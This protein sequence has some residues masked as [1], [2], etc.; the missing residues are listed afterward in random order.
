M[1]ISWLLH[2]VSP[3]IAQSIIWIDKA[4][5]MWKDLHDRLSQ[6]DSIRISELKKEIHTFKQRELAVTDY[7]TGLKIL[8]DE[9]LNLRPLPKCSCDPSCNCGAFQ[10]FKDQYDANQHERQLSH[11]T[12]TKA[13]PIPFAGYTNTNQFSSSPSK[14]QNSYKP[15]NSHNSRKN[16]G[17]NPPMCS[18]CNTPSHIE[19]TCFKKH[20]YPPNYNNKHKNKH[21]MAK[22]NYAA[23]S[24]Y[25][26]IDSE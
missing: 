17:K 15:K 12:K 3:Q 2:A 1:V 4:C 11:T 14:S 26:D 24:Q 21:V 8:Y 6:G 13:G 10:A 9:S 16:Y 18:Y 7:Y 19:D 23:Q 20:G 5:D 22:V 25:G